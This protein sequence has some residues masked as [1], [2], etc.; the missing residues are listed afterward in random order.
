M[1]IFLDPCPVCGEDVELLYSDE[2]YDSW[3]FVRCWNCG[4]EGDLYGT[5]EEAA[6]AWNA[7]RYKE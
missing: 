7:G 2:P 5:E 1:L 4:K 3:C 6:E